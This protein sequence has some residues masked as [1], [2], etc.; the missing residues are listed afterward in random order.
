MSEDYENYYWV[1]TEMRVINGEF[2]IPIEEFCKYTGLE[3][4]HNEGWAKATVTYNGSKT[5]F[6][7]KLF[8]NVLYVK[9]SDLEK[10]GVS[11]EH[12]QENSWY[13]GAIW[14]NVIIRFAK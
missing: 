1:E 7:G 9:L 4:S 11:V 10:I 14:H 5:E 12:T 3:I 13:D 6:D 8:D 2:Y